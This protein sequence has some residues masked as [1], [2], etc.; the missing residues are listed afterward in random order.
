MYRTIVV[1]YIEQF[2]KQLQPFF[3]NGGWFM[4]GFVIAAVLAGG[5]AGFDERMCAALENDPRIES[6][7]PTRFGW[8]VYEPASADIIAFV[9]HRCALRTVF[10]IGTGSPMTHVATVVRNKDGV[11]CVLDADA[12]TGVRLTPVVGYLRCFLRMGGAVYIRERRVPLTDEQDGLLT[13]FA[14]AQVGKPYTPLGQLAH[15]PRRIIRTVT[16][17]DPSFLFTEWNWHCSKITGAAHQYAGLL[18]QEVNVAALVPG[19]FMPP[20]QMI[21]PQCRW[22]KPRLYRMWL[23]PL[24]RASVTQVE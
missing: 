15:M 5:G 7:F 17:A 3:P 11:L 6:G 23:K 19:H 21:H 10:Q 12:A 18:A 9:S 8:E 22:G 16:E 1:Y 24:V 14:E 2:T 13:A 20:P 4:Y